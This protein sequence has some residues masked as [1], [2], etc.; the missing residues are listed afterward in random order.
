MDI[1]S[2]EESTCAWGINRAGTLADIRTL[3]A[4]P[5]WMKGSPMATLMYTMLMSLDGYIADTMAGS[6][7]PDPMKKF[8]HR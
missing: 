3:S 4:A 6:T 2:A 1:P 8:I 5:Q 7:G